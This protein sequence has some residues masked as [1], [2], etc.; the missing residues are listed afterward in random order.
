MFQHFFIFIFIPYFLFSFIL[1]LYKKKS[2]FFKKFF[3]KNQTTNK[4]NRVFTEPPP[5]MERGR[6]LSRITLAKG[7]G[8]NFRGRKSNSLMNLCGKAT[9]KLYIFSWKKKYF[10]LFFFIYHFFG[11][12][13][14][15]L[16]IFKIFLY[17][18]YWLMVFF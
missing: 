13:C 10:C 11:G 7:S 3:T 16:L 8:A 9:Q 6:T 14:S 15:V 1:C 4:K 12:F 2:I 18:F 5:T 17:Y